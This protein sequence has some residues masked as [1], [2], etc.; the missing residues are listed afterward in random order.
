MLL[1]IGCKSILFVPFIPFTASSNKIVLMKPHLCVAKLKGRMGMRKNRKDNDSIS[2]K[3]EVIVGILD[4][5][6]NCLTDK[7]SH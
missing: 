1:S 4:P 2:K 3:D 6:Q 7:V 5:N